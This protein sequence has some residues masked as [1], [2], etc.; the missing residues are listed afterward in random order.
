[1]NAAALVACCLLLAGC[2]SMAAAESCYFCYSATNAFC[3]DKD[4][5]LDTSEQVECEYGND[6][7]KSKEGCS[8]SKAVGK[9]FGFDFEEVNR[10]CGQIYTNVICAH[11][12]YF[13]LEAPQYG[14]TDTKVWECSC[15]G[16]NCNSSIMTTPS[17]M[18]ETFFLL[19]CMMAKKYM[20][21]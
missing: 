10:T 5:G 1:M 8:K 15:K 6:T 14:L 12:D 18:V 11:K 13:P 2:V 9:F 4:Y 17:F 19:C 21:M 16:N 3:T 20:Y 7:I